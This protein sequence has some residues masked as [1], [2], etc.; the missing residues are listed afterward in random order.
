MTS[1]LFKFHYGLG[2]TV[3]LAGLIRDLSLTYPG[4]YE[5]MVDTAWTQLWK[6]NPYVS[7]REI[8]AGVKPVNMRYE[9]IVTESRRGSG[10]HFLYG[11][12]KLF[13]ANTGIEVPLLYPKGDI[14]LSDAEKEPMI[15]GR[16][17]VIVAGSK[18]GI[19]TKQWHVRRYQEVVDTL[20]TRGLRFV[21]IGDSTT[22]DF[23]PP[24]NGVLS[25]VGKTKELRDLF[26]IIHGAEGVVCGVTGPMHLAACFDKPCVVLAG[27][28]EEPAHEAYVNSDFLRAF[29]PKCEKVKVPHRFLDSMGKLH[30]CKDKSCWRSLTVPIAPKDLRPENKGRICLEPVRTVGE[31]PVPKCLDIISTQTVIDAVLSYYE[32]G[33][34]T[35]QAPDQPEPGWIRKP[36]KMIKSQTPP[37]TKPIP[38]I[39]SPGEK[40]RGPKR[41]WDHPTIGGKVTIF[42]LCWGPHADL[43]KRCLN[44]ILKTVPLNRMDLRVHANEVCPETMAYL[45]TLPLR[46]LYAS[47]HNVFKYPAMRTMF[48]DRTCPI[49][50]KQICW[51]DDDSYAVD[52]L[53]M[54]KSLEKVIEQ[55]PK[56]GRLYGIKFFHDIN[57]YAKN[58]WQPK[59]W[60]E[61]AT[62]WRGKNLLV[63]GKAIAAPNGSVLEFVAGGWW[64]MA[65]EMIVKAGIPDVR[66]KNNGGDIVCGTAAAQN[67][68]KIV[69]WNDKK[70]LVFSSGAKRRGVTHPFPWSGP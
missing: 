46:K 22:K 3:L 53:W 43:A 58:G 60:F 49:T 30:C 37:L 40:E 17:W 51:F 42:V 14:H 25:S 52:P 11:M 38:E 70:S 48:H 7:P 29:G 1:L 23:H 68:G 39:L 8:R 32:D 36:G 62:W 56:G 69:H 45:K 44:S 6:R 26:S 63:K 5:I 10:R 27:G 65:S 4:K 2:D 67:G 15:S 64:I 47:D 21:Q 13:M 9:P 35:A 54:E 16:Y 55:H 12:H 66:L 19:T 57:I 24:L 34:L 41:L 31:T 28:R 61:Q 20:R 33:T 18:T 59:K 50:T